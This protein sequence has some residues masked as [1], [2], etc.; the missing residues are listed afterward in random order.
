LSLCSLPV[1]KQLEES[2]RS[3][4]HRPAGHLPDLAVCA[5]HRSFCFSLLRKSF[6]CCRGLLE[7][8]RRQETALPSLEGHQGRHQFACHGQRGPVAVAS[9]VPGRT[10][11]AAPGCSAARDAHFVLLVSRLDSGGRLPDHFPVLVQ[12]HDR[13]GRTLISAGSGQGFETNRPHHR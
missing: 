10:A 4:L 8:S 2:L 1:P 3:R 9:A 12:E 11:G 13:C 5:S 7:L 6:L